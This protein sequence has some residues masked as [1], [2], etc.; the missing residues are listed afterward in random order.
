MAG[1]KSTVEE[2]LSLKK[3]SIWEQ[4]TE[5]QRG[6][7]E[8]ISREYMDFISKAKTERMVTGEFVTLLTDRGF[9]HIDDV[10]KWRAGTRVYMT[11][12]GKNVACAVLGK[13]PLEEGANLVASHSDS[14][15][16]DLKQNPLYEDAE[17]RLALFK[18]HYYGGIKKYQWVNIPLSIHGI[19]VLSDG[20]TIDI[21]IGEDPAD[22][23]FTIC[24]LLPH[25]YRKKQADRKLQEGITGEELNVLLASQ[26]HLEDKTKKKVKLWVLDHL[27]KKYGMV[28]EDFV[29]SE[30]EVVPAGNAREVGFDKSLIGAYG[31]DDRICAFTSVRAL[32]EV[33][34]PGRTSIALG[35]D[36]EEIG[37]DGPTSIKSRFM[38]EFYSRLLELKD[39]DYPDRKIRE[40]LSNSIAISSDVNG[41]VNPS[42]K[43]VHELQNAA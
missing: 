29:S 21:H 4:A 39:P 43:D 36:K 41:A 3:M 10:S 6:E 27:H 1:K 7:I 16:L 38:E 34:T 2:T 15:R 33:H 11:N 20:R 40:A 28:E 5:R 26:P 37:S 18:T 30:F 14:P 17:T 32:M 25:L 9:K 35:V 23:V 12:R 19:V 22:P 8:N 13:A 42:F 24:D 31:Q